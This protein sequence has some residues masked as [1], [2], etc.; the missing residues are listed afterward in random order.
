MN[1]SIS[2]AGS[3]VAEYRLVVFEDPE[4]APRDTDLE[5]D[6]LLERW[7]HVVHSLSNQNPTRPGAT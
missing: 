6:E 2:L 1:L 7:D 4:A 3:P 5:L